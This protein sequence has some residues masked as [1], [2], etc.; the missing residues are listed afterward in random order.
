MLRDETRLRDAR[1]AAGQSLG[2]RVK[3]LRL[4]RGL[5]LAQV[6]QAGSVSTSTLSKIENDRLSPT[7]ETLIALARGLGVSVEQLFAE[8]SEREPVGRRAVT[9][10]GEGKRHS[11]AAY[12]YEMLC[13]EI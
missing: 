12:D 10:K 7:F 8:S 9:R 4:D 5:T 6:G 11:T 1:S 2:E 13:T 3:Q